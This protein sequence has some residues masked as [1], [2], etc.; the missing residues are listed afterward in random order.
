[1][2]VELG[3]K[4]RVAAT[5]LFLLAALGCATSDDLPNTPQARVGVS[6][7]NPAG[8]STAGVQAPSDIQPASHSTLEDSKLF[9]AQGIYLKAL[10]IFDQKEYDLAS[11]EFQRA[12]EVDPT[13]YMAWFKK[14]LCQYERKRYDLE[15]DCYRRCLEIAPDYVPALLNL[16]NAY[17]AQDELEKAVPIYRKIL[18]IEPTHSVALYNVGICYFDLQDYHSS[19]EFLQRFLDGHP[20][21]GYRGKA[22]LL[23]KRAHLRLDAQR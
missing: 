13:F 3:P 9:R 10:D 6:S 16:A 7:S 2:I 21:D 19:V 15:I 20:Q 4:G 23:L 5:M 22:E 12:L 8:D 17:L 1:M 11:L 14:G 18:D